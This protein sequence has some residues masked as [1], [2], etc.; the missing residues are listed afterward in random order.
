MICEK[1]GKEFFE[2]WRRDPKTRKTPCRFC[3]R[4][5]ANSRVHSRETKEKISNG[6]IQYVK[7]NPEKVASINLAKKEKIDAKKAN[8]NYKK[9][10][11][12]ELLEAEFNTLKHERLK[13]RILLEQ[14]NKCN[15]CGLSEWRGKPLTLE[16]EHKD[17]NNQNNERENLECLCP[18]CHSLTDTWR[19]RNKWPGKAKRVK[20]K[21]EELVEAFIETGSIRQTLLKVGLVA[22]GG[23]YGRVKKALTV[24][25]IE[26]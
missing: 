3:S 23:N 24:R 1:C 19:G 14:N 8:N 12:K 10:K 6:I 7:E 16:L 11:E 25:G 9:L 17:G 21:D 15:A 20:V 26:Y 22:K 18:N 5:C 13:N 2:D 4:N